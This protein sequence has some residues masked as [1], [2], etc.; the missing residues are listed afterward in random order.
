VGPAGWWA[1]HTRCVV[2]AAGRTR[3]Q[4]PLHSE[5]GES[6]E[7]ARVRAMSIGSRCKQHR[8][9]ALSAAGRS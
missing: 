9:N 6:T 5:V 7:S 2:K 8:R 3:T 1:V 4:L